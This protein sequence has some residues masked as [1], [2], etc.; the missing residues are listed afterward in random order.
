MHRLRDKSVLVACIMAGTE[1]R[2][3]GYATVKSDD[4]YPDL[5]YGEAFGTS[6]QALGGVSELRGF[7]LV[8]TM[9][10]LQKDSEAAER[11]EAPTDDDGPSQRTG[12]HTPG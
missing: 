11:A 12:R 7:W 3:F 6:N 4:R 2:A 8:P 5:R 10:Q 9:A 1:T